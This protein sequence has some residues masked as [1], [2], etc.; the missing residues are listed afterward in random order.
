MQ[1]E[2]GSPSRVEDKADYQSMDP[3]TKDVARSELSR[4]RADLSLQIPPGPMDYT[5]N[6]NGKG[7]VQFHGSSIVASSE[8][9]FLH[10]LSFKNQVSAVDKRSSLLDSD[11]AATSESRVVP[12][13]A[14]L[15]TYIAALPWKKCA[16]LPVTPA[17]VL[18][19][20]ISNS[21]WE[22]TCSEQNP[23]RKRRIPETVSRSLSV[24]LR[25]VVILRSLS[26][27][28]PKELTSTDTNDGQIRSADVEDGDEEIPEEDAVCRVCLDELCDG[29]NSFKMEC[30]CK[31]ALSLIHEKCAVKWFRI[32]GNKKCD[33][34]GQE[35]RNLP[36]TLFRMQSSGQRDNGDL[37]IRQNSNSQLT[38]AWHDVVVLLLISTMCYFF[39]LEQLLVDDMKSHA[40]EIAAPSS[41]ILG[42]LT[43]M[44]AIIFAHREYVWA[45]SAFQFALVAIFLHL[46]YSSVASSRNSLCSP[47]CVVSR[48]WDRN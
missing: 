31:G 13:N 29:E 27:P 12:E 6:R 11:P 30:S 32:K 19:P 36:V 26:I 24:P 25:N 2:P 16:S 1:D 37:N 3:I 41:V 17:S 33:V 47:V 18:S 34:C 39:F 21:G 10:G 23:S 46:F 38:R 45:Y 48:F 4:K 42:S 44:F 35:V 22:K 14:S 5:S 8:G 40:I 28:T 9:V 15:S 43:S 20:S 7:Q